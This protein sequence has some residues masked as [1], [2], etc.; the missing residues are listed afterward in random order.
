[1][2]S[3]A[4]NVVIL[5]VMVLGIPMLVFALLVLLA[6]LFEWARWVL[7]KINKFIQWLCDFTE[8]SA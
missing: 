6:I 5:A 1:M 8:A 4:V 2:T 3:N 7:R